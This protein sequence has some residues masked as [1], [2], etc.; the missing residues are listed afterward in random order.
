MCDVPARSFLKNIVGH[1]AKKACERCAVKGERERMRTVF[2]S[3]R[4]SLRTDSTFRQQQDREHHRGET[5]LSELHP[6][7]TNLIQDFPLDYMHLTC[8]GTFKRFLV[9]LSGGF[10]DVNRTHALSKEELS[11]VDEFISNLKPRTPQEFQRKRQGLKDISNW[12]ANEFRL[13]F[14]FIDVIILK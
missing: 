11:C 4:C 6:S 9:M 3:F 7:T 14:L 2:R 10:G 5:P 13:F 8:L 12:K 1:N